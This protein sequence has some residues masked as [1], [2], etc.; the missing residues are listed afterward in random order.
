MDCMVYGRMEPGS[1]TTNQPSVTDKF[2]CALCLDLCY[3]ACL[4][5]SPSLGLVN[6]YI[7]SA[8]YGF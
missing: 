6:M 7:N 1:T 3:V 4:T 2:S 8:M 5:I